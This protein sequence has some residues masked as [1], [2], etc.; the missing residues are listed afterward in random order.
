VRIVAAIITLSLLLGIVLSF[1]KGSW[2]AA[3][4]ASAVWLFHGLRTGFIT[5]RALV[6]T[7]VV[8]A[9]F[10]L[11]VPSLRRMPGLMLQRWM[12]HGSAVSNQERLRYIE[13]AVS[14]IREHPVSGVGLERFGE[15]YAKTRRLLRGPD[16]PHNGYLMVAVELGIPALGCLLLFQALVTVSA[17]VSVREGPP[18]VAPLYAAL[19]AGV[20]ALLVFQMFSAEPLTARTALVVMALCLTVPSMADHEEVD[21]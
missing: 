12:S 1:S 21:V 3:A 20:V 4:S 15:E 2:L 17:F 8:L 18:A 19:S 5:R 11:L 13:T 9:L 6:R 16:D 10:V 7:V 14:L